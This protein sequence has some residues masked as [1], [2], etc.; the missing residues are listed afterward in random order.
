VRDL[1]ERALETLYLQISFYVRY[2]DDIAMAI[3]LSSVNDILKV[4]NSLLD[5][6]F[7]FLV[8]MSLRRLLDIRHLM[9]QF[10]ILYCLNCNA[11]LE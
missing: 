10:W 4:F 1:E 9:F 3:P 6:V 7:T 8:N 2:V 5:F 11:R